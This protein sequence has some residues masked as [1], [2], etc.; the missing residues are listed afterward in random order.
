MQQFWTTLGIQ[1]WTTVT[2]SLRR[3]ATLTPPAARRKDAY[4]GRSL[5]EA[6]RVLGL[7]R[8]F[9]AAGCANVVGSLWK[10]DDEATAALMAQF[11][12]ELRQ[13]KRS[14]LEALREAQLTLYR[15]PERIPAL[16][17]SRGR[18]DQEHTVKLG[19]K[20][21]EPKPGASAKTT[22]VKLWAA[23]ILSGR[24]E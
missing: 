17:G 22:P 18:I 19:S 7:Q 23:F 13:N 21:P 5:T 8:A 20:P 15:H 10:V 14:P 4:G 12:H 1:S 11:Y 2:Q 6:E 9:H 3:A 24:G 16:A